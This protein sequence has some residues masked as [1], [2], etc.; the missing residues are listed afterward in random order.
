[1]PSDGLGFFFF[2][3][4]AGA[5]PDFVPGTRNFSPHLGHFTVRPANESF[6]LKDDLQLP[7]DALI[8]I[9]K[10]R[11][12]NFVRLMELGTGGVR[13]SLAQLLHF[14]SLSRLNNP[15]L[16]VLFRHDRDKRHNFGGGRCYTRIHTYPTQSKRL[17]GRPSAMSQR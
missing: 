10:V 15:P 9:V 3:S 16:A 4:F 5:A 8:A 11:T 13:N 12:M 1:M 17:A 6:A 14:D 2:L 7:Q